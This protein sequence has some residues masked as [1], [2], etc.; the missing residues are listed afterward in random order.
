MVETLSPQ[1]NRVLELAS[2]GHTDKGIADAL[3]ISTTT[4]ITYWARIRSKMGNHSRSELVGDFVRKAAEI[5]VAALQ[6]RLDQLT[7][8]NDTL[9]SFID[10]APEAMLIVDPDGTIISGNHQAGELLECDASLFPGLRVGTFIPEEFHEAHQGHRL[11]YMTD[12]HRLTIGHEGGV[13][14]V[15]YTKRR[16]RGL[17]TINLA[18]T[19]AG[20]AV[21][22]MLRP[23]YPF[24]LPT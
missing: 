17:V 1:E 11:R 18:T 23:L 19:P 13:E 20:Q 3:D 14:I 10:L 8:T 2:Q 7:E 22:V 5:E 21:V 12:P 6:S 16:I 9:H 4:V 15:T 24:E